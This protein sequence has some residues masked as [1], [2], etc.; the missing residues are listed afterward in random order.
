MQPR[1]IILKAQYLLGEIYYS[2][3]NTNHDINKII[4]YFN[5][6]AKNMNDNAQMILGCFYY[7]G[8]F[9]KQD[10]NKAINYFTHSAKQNNFYAQYFLGEIYY[11]GIF[12]QRNIKK[13][14]DFLCKSS[15]M[16]YFKAKNNLGVIYKNGEG[17][18]KKIGNSIAIFKEG[19]RK[20]DYYSCYNL[21]R[22]FYFANDIDKNIEEFQQLIKKITNVSFFPG[23]LFSFYIYYCGE[24]KNRKKAEKCLN[25]IINNSKVSFF[26]KY[27][28]KNEFDN[29]YCDLLFCKRLHNF[30]KEYDL[31]YSININFENDFIYFMK[32]GVFYRYSNTIL[33]KNINDDFYE[34]FGLLI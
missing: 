27:Y 34:G 1:I 5:E 17:G 30:L 6:S 15:N 2:G 7:H 28:I 29:L 24:F 3:I 16:N 14:I 31:I 19:I 10:V 21:S 4:Y 23:D 12:V 8:E 9:Y 20:N 11:D 25:Q 32:T 13:S 33:V 18:K 26:T 22:V